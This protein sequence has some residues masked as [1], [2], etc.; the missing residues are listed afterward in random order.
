[1]IETFIMFFLFSLAVGQTPIC[2]A[3]MCRNS[4]TSGALVEDLLSIGCDPNEVHQA[5]GLAPL[6][7]ATQTE[8][9]RAVKALLR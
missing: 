6:L 3:L 7:L 9:V 4:Q 5:T 1:M 2:S 8:S